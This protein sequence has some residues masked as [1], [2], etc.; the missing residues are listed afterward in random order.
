MKI[1]FDSV[2]DGQD[3]F[4]TALLFGQGAVLTALQMGK[5]PFWQRYVRARCL[6]D[7][8]TDGQVAF[9]TAL[10]MARCLFD[11]VTF[12]ARCFL[13]V[14]RL[15]KLPFWQCYIWTRFRPI[16]SILNFILLSRWLRRVAGEYIW[17]FGWDNCLHVKCKIFEHG[18]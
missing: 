17:H 10:Q 15:D 18:H 1:T 11:S 4:L 14:L 13:T 9:L 12:W 8:V 7:S 16:L 6:F 2:Y 3:A 5:V